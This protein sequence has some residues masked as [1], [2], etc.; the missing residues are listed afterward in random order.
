M[1][2]NKQFCRSL[3]TT[4]ILSSI[5]FFGSAQNEK[6]EGKAKIGITGGFNFASIN[7]SN[8]D[9]LTAF[10]A[11][12]YK[13]FKLVPLFKFQ[14]GLLYVRNGA[15]IGD[16]D[17]RL[18]YLTLPALL[19]IKIGPMYATTGFTGSVRV[20]ASSKIDDEVEKLDADDLNWY[21]L[22]AQL[23]VGVKILFIGV[24]ARYNWGLAHVL[25]ESSNVDYNN[26][27]FHLGLTVNL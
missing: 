25:K 22:G 1:S 14:T 4:I 21:D 16:M 9:G 15:S 26:R 3:F 2:F 13:D 23:G 19:K 11:G 24:E 27:Y 6:G 17:I 10:Y 8:T 18:D 5:A 12:I 7:E 20:G